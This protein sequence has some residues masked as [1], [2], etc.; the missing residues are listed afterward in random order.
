MSPQTD[1][2]EQARNRHGRE[3][4]DSN[5]DGGMPRPGD[6]PSTCEPID[7]TPYLDGTIK[8][9]KPT[10]GPRSDGVRL[11]YRGKMHSLVGESEA[12]KTW[13]ALLWCALE[14][15]AGHDVLFIDCEDGPEGITERL[16]DLG[17]L[18]AVPGGLTLLR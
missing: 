2:R 15:L 10:L 3:Q 8:P 9:V 16:L 11:L 1:Q 18:T 12:G 13:L 6:F 4:K 17:M 14:I 7:L 5:G